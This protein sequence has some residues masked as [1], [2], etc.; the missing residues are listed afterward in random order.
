MV[1]DMLCMLGWENG[2]IY[3]NIGYIF[4]TVL[5]CPAWDACATTGKDSKGAS[6]GCGI[7]TTALPIHKLRDFGMKADSGHCSRSPG[8]PNV[9]TENTPIKT[10]IFTVKTNGASR[11]PQ[12][13]DVPCAFIF[14]HRK[15]FSWHRQAVGNPAD[16]TKWG[17]LCMYK[18]GAPRLQK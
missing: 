1:L 7:L 14:C 12:W 5:P 8:G 13:R 2:I 10:Y 17:E 4:L 16:C 3:V 9:V 6:P 18:G 15:R 11:D